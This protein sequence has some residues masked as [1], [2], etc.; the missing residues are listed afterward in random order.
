MTFSRLR[1]FVFGLLFL[2]GVGGVL[3]AQDQLSPEA[4][5]KVAADFINE[6][7]KGKEFTDA[8]GKKHA[9]RFVPEGWRTVTLVK[10]RWVLVFDPPAGPYAQVSFAA[11]GKDPKV[12]KVGYATE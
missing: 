4:A 7:M 10:G 2:F 8:A 3:H 1:I 12:E 9:Y 11:D 6:Q 5:R